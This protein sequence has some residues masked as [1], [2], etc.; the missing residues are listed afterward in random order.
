MYVSNISVLIWDSRVI[1]TKAG[2]RVLCHHILRDFLFSLDSYCVGL[3]S[4]Q[5]IYTWYTA[6]P[7]Q[8]N[9][10]GCFILFCLDEKGYVTEYFGTDS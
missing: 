7:G 9:L 5:L 8:V 4:R 3:S 1:A 10:L 2:S 6:G